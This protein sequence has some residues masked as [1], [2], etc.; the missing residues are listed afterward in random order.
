MRILVRIGRLHVD[1]I[2][3]LELFQEFTIILLD[4]EVITA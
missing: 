1:P 4:I 3:C 2:L